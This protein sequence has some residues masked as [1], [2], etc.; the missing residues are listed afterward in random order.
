MTR[1]EIVSYYGVDANITDDGEKWYLFRA[2]NAQLHYGLGFAI[3]AHAYCNILNRR[4]D[5]NQYYF[6]EITDS[7]TLV[8]LDSGS[9]TDGF[10]LDEELD[11]QKE[12][13]E[14]I[15]EEERKRTS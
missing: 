4:R 2:F 11:T 15:T 3:E 6:E 10:R 8:S 1:D 12:Q 5:L 14:W 7:A 9:D 13:D